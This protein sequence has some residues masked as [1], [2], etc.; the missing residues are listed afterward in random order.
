[1]S[2]PIYPRPGIENTPA[3]SRGE[4]VSTVDADVLVAAGIDPATISTE[5]PKGSQDAKSEADIVEA[6]VIRDCLADDL[7]H[8]EALTFAGAFWQ[9]THRAN[10][11][12]ARSTWRIITFM[13]RHPHCGWND[14]PPELLD[15]SFF[16]GYAQPRKSNSSLIH[17]W[18]ANGSFARAETQLNAYP[19]K[20][21]SEHRRQQMSAAV[22]WERDVQARTAAKRKARLL[23]NVRKDTR[24][25]PRKEAKS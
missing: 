3:I 4:A 1:M 19:L 9:G 10:T 21:W 13:N 6:E 17:W 22:A 2:K 20:R 14:I 25:R 16:D 7:S 18:F 24:V 5:K 11:D 23:K 12:R 8:S 15:T